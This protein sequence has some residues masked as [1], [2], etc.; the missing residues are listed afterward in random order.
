VRGY[1]RCSYCRR[2]GQMRVVLHVLWGGG[3]SSIVVVPLPQ[4]HESLRH[5]GT[6][7][8]TAVHQPLRF[9]TRRTCTWGG[10][11]KRKTTYTLPQSKSGIA[12]RIIANGRNHKK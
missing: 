11:G 1:S 7:A 4:P 12:T 8:A 2:M 6:P 5:K 3:C 9:S 10:G